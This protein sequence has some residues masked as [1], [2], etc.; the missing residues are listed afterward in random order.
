MCGGTWGQYYHWR[1]LSE[2]ARRS[3]LAVVPPVESL[4]RT[5]RPHVVD[6]LDDT[7]DGDVRT[8][9]PAADA[10]NDSTGSRSPADSRGLLAGG[11]STGGDTPLEKTYFSMGCSCFCLRTRVLCRTNVGDAAAAGGWDTLRSWGVVVATEVSAV[12]VNARLALANSVLVLAATA[13]TRSRRLV[14]GEV[15]VRAVAP[16]PTVEEVRGAEDVTSVGPDAEL[17]SRTLGGAE[18]DGTCL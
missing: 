8:P 6:E 2:G 13:I 14:P 11:G 15:T 1:P 7:A 10:S 5:L 18:A 9:R 16:F 17:V 3:Y 4:S 12:L